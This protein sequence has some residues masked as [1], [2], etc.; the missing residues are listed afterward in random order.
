MPGPLPS[1]PPARLAVID[2]VRRGA[3]TVN[4]IAAELGVT[5]NAVRLHLSALE[6]DGLLTR[7]GVQRSGKAGQPAAEYDV[8][9]GGEVVLSAAYPPALSALVRSISARLNSRAARALF[10][11]AGRRMADETPA[12]ATGSLAARA[13]SC[14]A[15]LESLGGRVT[16]SNERS[17]ATLTGAGCPLASAVRAEPGTCSLIEALLAKHGNVDVEQKCHHGEQPSCRFVLKA[18]S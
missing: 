4:A 9:P 8:S 14:A 17:S 16:V 6:R 15:L 3:R 11:D 5:D 2:A 1:L 18:R 12:P 10:L 13:S 7:R